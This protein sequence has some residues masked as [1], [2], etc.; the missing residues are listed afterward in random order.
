MSALTVLGYTP[1]EITAALRTIDTDA[2]TVEQIIR[3]VLKGSV[4]Q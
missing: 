3:E 1:N 4:K 2:L